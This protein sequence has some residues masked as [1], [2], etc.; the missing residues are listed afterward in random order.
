MDT[1]VIDKESTAIAKVSGESLSLYDKVVSLVVKDQPTYDLAV[2]LYK[3]S[4]AVEKAV[5]AAHDPVVSHWHALHSAACAALKTDLDKVITAKKLAKSKADVWSQEQ[6][7]VRAE[8]ER[9]DREEAERKHREEER[10]ALAALEA[11]RKRIAAEEEEERLRLAAEAEQS[12]ASKE[13]VTQ[14]LDTPLPVQE[15]PIYVPPP[16]VAPVVAPTFQKAAGFAP[17]WNYSAEFINL[18]EL[19]KA[20][21]SNPHFIGFLSFNEP[22]IDALARRTKDAFS[23]P[24]CKLRKERV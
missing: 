7:R 12:G 3:T 20:V 1:Q 21:T 23:L 19:V 11:E 14:I 13:Q 24:G 5:H 22:E 4:L 15:A 9:R 17:R 16:Y 2:E 6:E 8:K 10:I 18:E